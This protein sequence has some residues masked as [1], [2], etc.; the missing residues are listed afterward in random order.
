MRSVVVIATLV[1]GLFASAFLASEK[2]MVQ[3]HTASVELSAS[4]PKALLPDFAAKPEAIPVN[5]LLITLGVLFIAMLCFMLPLYSIT[6][7]K[8][9]EALKK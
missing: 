6:K 5:Q 2:N 1:I 3:H 9:V 8:M 7:L 4:S